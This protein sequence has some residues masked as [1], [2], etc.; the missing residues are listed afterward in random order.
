M[1]NRTAGPESQELTAT[2]T[3]QDLETCWYLVA[4]RAADFKSRG[5][6]DTEIACIALTTLAN[7]LATLLGLPE[8]PVPELSKSM[9]EHLG[10]WLRGVEQVG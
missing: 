7:K 9:T 5:R 1:S 10:R 3:V 6:G 2:L 4:E 8:R